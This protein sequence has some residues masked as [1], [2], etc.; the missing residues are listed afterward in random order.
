MGREMDQSCGEQP[1]KDGVMVMAEP[2]TWLKNLV[3]AEKLGQG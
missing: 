2:E 3:E 1:W